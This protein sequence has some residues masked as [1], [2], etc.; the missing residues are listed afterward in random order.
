MNALALAR[1]VRPQG[2]RNETTRSNLHTLCPGMAGNGGIEQ[3]MGVS[4]HGG[5]L[6]DH[7]GGGGGQEG[8]EMNYNEAKCAALGAALGLAM[9]DRKP[10]PVTRL[11]N[12]CPKCH[13]GNSTELAVCLHCGAQMPQHIL[14]ECSITKKGSERCH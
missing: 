3:G 11:M 12:I 14:K 6:L 13:V 9:A 4:L 8:E 1:H 7:G 5:L 2:G 10:K